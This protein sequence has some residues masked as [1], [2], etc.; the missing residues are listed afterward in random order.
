[1]PRTH[2]EAFSLT[3][4]SDEI[5]NID[6]RNSKVMKFATDFPFGR[7]NFQQKIQSLFTVPVYPGERWQVAL[8]NITFYYPPAVN[9]PDLTVN[10]VDIHVS[11]C[12]DSRIGSQLTDIIY[13]ISPAILPNI[14]TLVNFVPGDIT[15]RWVNVTDDLY[16]VD[17]VTVRLTYPDGTPLPSTLPGSTLGTIVNLAF[18]RKD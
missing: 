18:V 7:M 17:S 14:G 8:S 5:G 2:A 10:P 11:L 9:Q 1:M 4:T 12:R 15:P 6:T 13:R 16:S 3:L